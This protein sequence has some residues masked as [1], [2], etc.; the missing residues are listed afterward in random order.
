M[1]RP[2]HER[3]TLFR[4]TRTI[5]ELALD[6]PQVQAALLTRA[7]PLN[8]S[9]V[10]DP[11]TTPGIGYVLYWSQST[12]RVPG[13]WALRAAV[14]AAD[15]LGL[16]VVIH[17]GVD[18]TYPS[19]NA[20]HHGALL[21]A[22][23]ELARDAMAAGY[24]VSGAVRR[25][26]RGAGPLRPQDD[27]AVLARLADSA[28]LIVTDCLPTAGV[29]TR[30]THLAARVPCAVWA[31]D[32]YTTMGA[33]STH[34]TPAHAGGPR[35]AFDA[36]M[37]RWLVE[38]EDRV[39]HHPV[40]H[41]DAVAHAALSEQ[42]AMAVGTPAWTA[43]ED[44]AFA[45]QGAAQSWGIALA[46]ASG[47]DTSVMLPIGVSVGRAA[48]LAALAAFVADRLSGYM[49]E[50][51]DAAR[52]STTHLSPFLHYGTIGPVEVCRAVLAAVREGP[53]S[54]RVARQ[55]SAA[56]VLDQVAVRRDLAFS[57]ALGLAQ[58]HGV[59]DAADVVTRGIPAWARQ[60]LAARE[61]ARHGT[62]WNADA[63]RRAESGHPLWDAMQSSLLQHGALHNYARMQ[64]GKAIVRW[65]PDADTALTWLLREND[66]L[67]LDGRDPNGIMGTLWCLG[68]GERPFPSQ[69]G[70]GTVRAM[71][72]DRASHRYDPDAFIRRVHGMV[73]PAPVQGSLFD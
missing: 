8:T 12:R 72:L 70:F 38:V 46:E 69:P 18:A 52:D 56:G 10:R 65:A 43:F 16:P 58:S 4:M 39:P 2:A 22:A 67:A 63:L 51:M 60:T 11:R 15:R 71:S 55:A 20:R 34:K 5:P 61:P 40:H 19:A 27:R 41:G 54:E 29:L 1:Q 25:T 7:T 64:W 37:P 73:V 57:L 36:A 3:A 44:P 6:A 45:A 66:R 48:G 13:N 68:W 23:H 62:A 47:T 33:F 9:P 21:T 35:A 53:E 14:R 42:I 31:V 32:G 24:V 30:A 26:G 50:R 59:T 28:A 49:A 17:Q